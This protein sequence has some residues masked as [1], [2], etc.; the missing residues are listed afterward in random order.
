LYRADD[1]NQ[2]DEL[3]ETNNCLSN[4]YACC[5]P[6][7]DV[8]KKVWNKQKEEWVEE[9]CAPL[10]GTVRFQCTVVNNGECCNLTNILVSDILSDSLKYADSATVNGKPWEPEEIGPNQF[11]WNLEDWV[12]EPGQEI[13]IE[14]NAVVVKLS[15]TPDINTQVARAYCKD[16]GVWVEDRDTA[17]VQP[18]ICG[19][20]NMDA[21]VNMADVMILWYDIADYPSE[22]AWTIS[23]ECAAD[24]NCD[25]VINM[26]DVM[27]LWY[28]IADYPSAG[29]WVINCCNS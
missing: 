12:L 25:G 24:V 7:I 1:Y 2:I 8:I 13:V 19:D 15:E 23:N 21:K 3:S 27:I 4:T 5:K 28:D 10:D 26:A 20:V 29:A 18:Y 6:S 11:Q 17:A 14:F 16:F 9:V 22:G